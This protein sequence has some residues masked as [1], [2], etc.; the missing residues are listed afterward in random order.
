MAINRH[1]YAYRMMAKYDERGWFDKAQKIADEYGYSYTPG[2]FTDEAL[3]GMD[4]NSPEYMFSAQT[5]E[6]VEIKLALAEAKLKEH[7]KS[8][9]LIVI[10]G[11]SQMGK[12]F[13]AS[14]IENR[15]HLQ[16]L[17]ALGITFSDDELRYFMYLY[18]NQSPLIENALPTTFAEVY[19]TRE[20]RV[21][22]KRS[23]HT[24]A[25]ES[26]IPVEFDMREKFGGNQITC[27]SSQDILNKLSSG[28][29]VIITT[30]LPQIVTKLKQI[31]GDAQTTIK[32]DSQ[33]R[34]IEQIAKT[35]RSRHRLNLEN[36]NAEIEKRITAYSVQYDEY[37]KFTDYD[38]LIHNNGFIRSFE[39]SHCFNGTETELPDVE[40]VASEI[41][42]KYLTQSTIINRK[43]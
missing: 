26:E 27:Y 29:I 8:G 6:L 11:L 13:Y 36:I 37:L 30:T 42:N 3:S 19:K 25:T 4:V 14:R 9:Q 17:Q 32:I 40:F 18:Q 20:K 34:T 2:E 12:D 15:L 10:Y 1:G 31:A 28:K 21:D 39:N 22:D 16:I 35:E 24:V 38:Y 23:L 7:A 43:Q 41:L 5:R 33:K